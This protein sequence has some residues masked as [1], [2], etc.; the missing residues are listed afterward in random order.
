MHAFLT[1][2]NLNFLPIPIPNFGVAIKRRRIELGLNRARAATSLG[3]RKELWAQ[4]E[5]QGWVPTT[6]NE[7]F[8]RSLAAT[9]EIRYE[10]LA[11]SIT[12]LE[13]HLAN[14]EE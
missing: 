1:N 8:L 4:I 14:T 3:I 11:N 5:D 12:P 10:D 7:N 13:M 9:L 2:P 6:E